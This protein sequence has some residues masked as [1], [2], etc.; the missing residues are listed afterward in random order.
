MWTFSIANE[1]DAADVFGIRAESTDITRGIIDAAGYESVARQLCERF[2]FSSKVAMM[3]RES[4]SASRNGWSAMLFR[5]G[6]AIR[7]RR[8]HIQ[9]VYWV[10][11]GDSFAAGVDLRVNDRHA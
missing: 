1:E 3:L 2:A 7:S 11:G 4:I 9:I 10:G 8:Y 6:G 5:D